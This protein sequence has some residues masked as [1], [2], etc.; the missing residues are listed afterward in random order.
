MRVLPS[1]I[2]PLSHFDIGNR[3]FAGGPIGTSHAYCQVHVSYSDSHGTRGNIRRL[4]GDYCHQP[5]FTGRGDCVCHSITPPL[6]D[7]YLPHS[8]SKVTCIYFFSEPPYGPG[9]ILINVIRVLRYVKM[10]TTSLLAGVVFTLLSGTALAA[11][12]IE[13]DAAQAANLQKVGTTQIS[14]LEGSYD[15]AVDALQAKATAAHA[16]HYR[17]VELNTPSHSSLWSGTAVLYK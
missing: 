14:G 12:A 16:S 11:G 2:S 17:I 1:R 8:H 15:D 3:D 13:V 7:T 9:D 10:K 6:F 5:E 4:M